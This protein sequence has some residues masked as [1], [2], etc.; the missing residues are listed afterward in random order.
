MLKKEEILLLGAGEHSKVI[1]DCIL[2]SKS[3]SIIGLIDNST[4][5]RNVC[6][7]NI[8][9]NDSQL[10]SIFVSGCRNAFVAIGSIDNVLKRRIL[11]DKLQRIGFKQPI[12]VH[13]SAYVSKFAKIDKGCFIAAGAT[14]GPYAIIGNNSIINTHSSIDHDCKISEFVHIAPGSIL[15]GAVTI[16]ANT[17]I[18]TGSVI[19]NHIKI[20]SNCLI[21]AGSVVISDIPNNVKAYGNPCKIIATVK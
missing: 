6:G 18:G 19:I 17:H 4:K 21:G 20:G 12:L 2:A 13:P 5:I 11:A 9:G 3:Y 1:I 14:I 7:I 8:I 16:D 15:S 10:K